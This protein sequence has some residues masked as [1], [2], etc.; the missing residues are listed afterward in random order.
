MKRFTLWS[1]SADTIRSGHFTLQ[2]CNEHFTTIFIAAFQNSFY[3]LWS[4]VIIFQNMQTST[5]VRIMISYDHVY[6]SR[7]CDQDRCG[8]RLIYTAVDLTIHRNLCHL[9]KPICFSS[10]FLPFDS[11]Y[12]VTISF[13]VSLFLHVFASSL[14]IPFCWVFLF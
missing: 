3:F 13:T 14:L 8:A 2:C 4:H 9:S 6:T 1:L 7:L 10:F 5:F 11:T 12:F